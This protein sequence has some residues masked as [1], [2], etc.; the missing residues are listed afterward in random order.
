MNKKD[1][2]YIA[3]L[4]LPAVLISSCSQDD[5]SGRQSAVDDLISFQV[6]LPGVST[7]ATETDMLG[8]L[9]SGFDVTAFCPEDESRISADGT[10]GDYFSEQRVTRDGDGKFRS[11]FC[12]WPGNKDEKEGRLK[13]F[14][15]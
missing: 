6:S 12:R 4:S 3:I 7:R 8:A 5:I 2:S 9:A 11:D 14:A 13:F 10:L 1:L 15:F